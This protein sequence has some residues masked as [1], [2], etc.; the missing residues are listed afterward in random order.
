MLT[1]VFAPLL[2]YSQ[3]TSAT[4]PSPLGNFLPLSPFVML[5]HSGHRLARLRDGTVGA[6][7]AGPGGN[8]ADFQKPTQ[9]LPAELLTLGAHAHSRMHQFIIGRAASRDQREF[10]P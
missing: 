3:E 9:V 6:A 1:D 4:A 10:Q 8:A 7:F 2:S 5:Q